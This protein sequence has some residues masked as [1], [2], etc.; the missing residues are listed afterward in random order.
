MAASARLARVLTDSIEAATPHTRNVFGGRHGM[1]AVEVEALLAESTV[2]LVSTVG[3]EGAPHIA[4]VGPVFVDGRLYVGVP[5]GT[6]LAGNLRRSRDVAVA[7]VELPWR[8]HAFICGRARFLEE[9][10]EEIARVRAA[11]VAKHGWQSPV[12][13]EIAPGKVFGWRESAVAA[14]PDPSTDSPS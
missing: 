3:A 2:A 4:G 13:V 7:V 9:G 12:L 10:T 8:R 14:S 1:S 6:A 11:E 5:E